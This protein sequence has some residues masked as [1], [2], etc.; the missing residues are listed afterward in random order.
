LGKY[1]GTDGV[2]GVANQDLTPDLAFRLGRCVG[3]RLVVRHS[4]LDRPFV[5]IG[6]DTRRSGAMLESAMAAGLC[7]VGIDVWLLGVVPTPAVAWLTRRQGAGAGVMISA[8]H[9]PAPDN[10]IKIFSREGFKLPDAEEEA[11]ETLLDT[12]EDELPRPTGSHLGQIELRPD[13]VDAY[14]EA[15][16]D[17]IPEGLNGLKVALD[18][19]HGAAYAI[20]PRVFR[21]LGAQVTVLGDAPDGDN[22][23]AGVGSTHL[24]ALI[25][26]VGQGGHE[27]GIAFDGDADRCL[28]VDAGGKVVD[29]DKIM[30]LCARHLRRIGRLAS[31]DV[32]STV[33]SNMGFEE[34]I[35][36]E[37]GQVFRTRVGD[38]YVLDEMQR[39][40][41]RIGGEQ[42]GHVIFLDDNTTGD[43][44]MTALRLLAAIK[45]A[46]EPL[47]ALAGGMP[48]YPQLLRNVRVA[49]VA[50]WQDS[51]EI[52]AAIRSA[53][54]RLTGVGRLVVR[55]S[56]TEPLIR[57]MAEAKDQALV[58]AVVDGLISVITRA[59]T[60]QDKSP[61]A[62]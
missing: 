13:L 35:G 22:I 15:L 41:I 51:T 26:E 11:V 47:A 58:E 23:N 30:W 57:V 53:E 40:G 42:S 43:G 17:L 6:R 33:M 55:A 9:N 31:A 32:V 46:G 48:V 21:A 59:L 44:L 12:P 5:V 56:G 38:R 20:A 36:R 45:A 3:A 39:R 7:S 2:R 8:S 52:Q 49:S 25:E 34:A 14:E 24:G 61:A 27:L 19:A 18:C 16:C 50:G 60:H 4:G 62:T 37:G 29:G 1:F 10:G 54:E 28:A